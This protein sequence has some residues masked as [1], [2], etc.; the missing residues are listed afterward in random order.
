MR[1][2]R[3]SLEERLRLY[4]EVMRLRRQDLVTSG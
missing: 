3:R 4:E 2:K 1:R